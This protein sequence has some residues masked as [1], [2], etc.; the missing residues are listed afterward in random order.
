MWQAM[1]LIHPD[2]DSDE[3]MVDVPRLYV[4]APGDELYAVKDDCLLSVPAQRHLDVWQLRNLSHVPPGGLKDFDYNLKDDT[5]NDV[6]RAVGHFN[7]ATFLSSGPNAYSETC[8]I[9]LPLCFDTDHPRFRHSMMTTLGISLLIPVCGDQFNLASLAI[10]ATHMAAFPGQAPGR[11]VQAGK[12]VKRY[13]ATGKL[14]EG[15]DPDK[16]PFVRVT[17]VNDVSTGITIASVQI[18]DP[19]VPVPPTCVKQ[20]VGLGP[21]PP[22]CYVGAP[23]CDWDWL[24]AE[25]DHFMLD[26]M[27]EESMS[28]S[29]DTFL[30][31]LSIRGVCK[32]WLN[33]HD[34]RLVNDLVTIKTAMRKAQTTRLVSDWVAVRNLCSK[35]GVT[36]WDV[37]CTHSLASRREGPPHQV[38][39]KLKL[40]KH[41]FD[42]PCARRLRAPLSNDST[43]PV[44]AV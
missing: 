32:K 38:M 2:A 30:A 11:L 42:A 24:D 20:H 13:A 16:Y 5:G 19:H 1:P 23:T 3:E 31:F 22:E 29:Q 18:K 6:V 10:T 4:W 12:L 15:Y 14:T 40:G 44:W 21:R 36:A 9:F 28:G 27:L 8:G 43:P 33:V 39:M 7:A 41:Q 25:L 17:K 26:M 34:G 37:F 35:S